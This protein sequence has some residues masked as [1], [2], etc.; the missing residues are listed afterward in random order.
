MKHLYKIYYLHDPLDS[1][2]NPRY[3]GITRRSLDKR[4]KEHIEI[5]KRVKQRYKL[6]WIRKLLSEG[7]TPIINILEE[8]VCTEKEALEKENWYIKNLVNQ[9][10]KLTNCSSLNKESTKLVGKYNRNIPVIAIYKTTGKIYKNYNSIKEC[11]KDLN[12]SPNFISACAK[13]KKKTKDYIIVKEKDFKP[14][15]NYKIE[16]FDRR[17]FSKKTYLKK[18]RKLVERAKKVNSICIKYYDLNNSYLGKFKS[19]Q[20][21]ARKLSLHQSNI[22]KVLSGKRSHTGNFIFKYCEDIV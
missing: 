7:R 1:T 9:G 11:A 6:I 19:Q 22:N 16:D 10:Y 14:E 20:E 17:G 4:L 18:K 21:A 12:L 5:S 3:V 2:F 13:G 8:L 15:K